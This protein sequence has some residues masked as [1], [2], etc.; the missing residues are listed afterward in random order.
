MLQDVF[1]T[2]IKIELTTVISNLMFALLMD[3]TPVL[4]LN[5]KVKKKNIYLFTEQILKVLIDVIEFH[6]Q[7]NLRQQFPKQNRKTKQEL[8]NLNPG[9]M[10]FK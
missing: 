9:I 6:I 5:I 3:H 10:V 4:H 2:F 8:V 7:F 1:N